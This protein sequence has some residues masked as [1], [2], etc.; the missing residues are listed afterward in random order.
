MADAGTQGSRPST[1]GGHQQKVTSRV[2]GLDQVRPFP[3]WGF[4]RTPFGAVISISSVHL[5]CST[6]LARSSVVASLLG[7]IGVIALF[8]VDRSVPAS[9][10]ENSTSCY[11]PSAAAVGWVE[12]QSCM[13]IS[14]LVGSEEYF[15]GRTHTLAPSSVAASRIGVHGPAFL[16]SSAQEDQAPALSAVPVLVHV[17]VTAAV[18]AAEPKT[19]FLSL[20]L[21][22][23]PSLVQPSPSPPSPPVPSSPSPG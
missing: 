11:S 21:S 19:P 4:G 8:V 3:S 17:S 20:V 18:A 12:A 7:V 22:P 1:A 13:A 5:D 14:V 23:S 16:L 2:G 6:G 10:Q 15:S 9:F